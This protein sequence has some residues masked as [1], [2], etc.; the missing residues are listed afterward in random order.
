MLTGTSAFRN[1]R[2]NLMRVMMMIWVALT[3]SIFVYAIVGYFI[4][5]KRVPAIPGDTGERLRVFLYIAGGIVAMVSMGLRVF[6]FSREWLEGVLSRPVDLHRLANRRQAAGTVSTRL[7]DL[8]SMSADEQK[9]IG[10]LHWYFSRYVLILALNESIVVLG[11]ILTLVTAN[12]TEIL[13]FL[14]VGLLLNAIMV[15]HPK[16]LIDDA[17]GILLRI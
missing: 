7:E 15:G 13:V 3:A 8:E 6:L 1:A 2:K 5:A 16:S 14:A 11:L 17:E 10:L 12:A 4:A 9:V